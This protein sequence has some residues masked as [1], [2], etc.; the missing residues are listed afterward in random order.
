MGNNICNLYNKSLLSRIC[1]ELLK[2]NQ[3]TQILKWVKH[4]DRQQR[5]EIQMVVKHIFF[6]KSLLSLI[7]NEVKTM[8]SFSLANWQGFKDDDV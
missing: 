5:E 7:R 4:M 8:R 6:F 3:I 2:N 1:N